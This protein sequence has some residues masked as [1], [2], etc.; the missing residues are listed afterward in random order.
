MSHYFGSGAKTLRSV[1]NGPMKLRSYEFEG[2][3]ELL[4]LP[5]GGDWTI[6]QGAAPKELLKALQRILRDELGQSIRFECQLVEKDVIVAGGKYTFKP[7]AAHGDKKK[8][9][10][11]FENVPGDFAG[12]GSGTVGEM[13]SKLGDLSNRFIID[14]SE[15]PPGMKIAW[16]YQWGHRSKALRLLP[17]GS[18]EGLAT[19]R[20][21]LDNISKQTSLTFT[22]QRRKVPVWHVTRDAI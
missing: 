3:D 11:F 21:L 15:H 6:R 18:E 7:L 12:S 19:L 13:L 5:V 2:A 9:L 4:D 20:K 10:F 16:N 8:V 22:P 17:V 1:L 14:E